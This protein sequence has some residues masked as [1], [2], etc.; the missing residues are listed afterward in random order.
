V[1]TR[2]PVPELRIYWSKRERTYRD[3]KATSGALVYN[4]EKCTG[5]MLATWFERIEL[6]KRTLAQE[7]DARGYDLSTL[8]FS[9]RK[10]VT[11]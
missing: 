6:D 4:G 7:L 10:K 5:G 9:I 8:R 2:R 11:R 1:S 3:D